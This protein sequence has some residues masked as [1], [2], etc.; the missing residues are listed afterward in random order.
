[1]L[2]CVYPKADGQETFYNKVTRENRL[3][4]FLMKMKLGLP[5]TVLGSL[6]LVSKTS[7]SNIFF[8]VLNTLRAATKTWLYLPSKEAIKETMTS[9]F[10]NYSNFASHISL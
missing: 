1:M 4:L 5:F 9:C 10:E 8:N 2:K 3:L 6:F 7:A